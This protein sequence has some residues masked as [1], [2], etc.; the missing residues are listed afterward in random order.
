M[1]TRQSRIEVSGHGNRHTLAHVEWSWRVKLRQAER[2]LRSFEAESLDYLDK[3]RAG[4]DY[5]TDP[6]AGTIE[7]ILRA[8]YDPPMLLGAIVGDV[9]HNLRS[10]LDAIAWETC[11]RAGVAAKQ[12]S[13]VYFPITWRPSTWPGEAKSKLPCV[14]PD[15]ILEF[16]RLQPWYW[17]EQAR[18]MGIDIPLEDARGQPLW[19]LHELAKVDRHRTPHPLLART[20][21]T[22]LGTSE[23][24]STD[25]A[26]VQPAPWKPGDTILRW[27]IEPKERLHE[28]QPAG[29][30]IL[31]LVEDTDLR[32]TAAL[33]ALQDMIRSVSAALQHIE[34]EVLE[35]VTAEELAELQD[36]RQKVDAAKKALNANRRNQDVL[37]LAR[38]ERWNAMRREIA[39]LEGAWQQRWRELFQ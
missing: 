6:V 9:L 8:E 17:D 25:I 36:L 5:V 38:L 33:S 29:D 31:T 13:A 37:D 20:G 7:V 10:A 39:E 19:Q 21:D 18:G 26:L 24:M 4:F 22:W 27:I 15:Q 11:R 3:A 32:G 16:E 35:V 30:V 2:H 12:E 28:A 23:G 1:R 34:I 14:P